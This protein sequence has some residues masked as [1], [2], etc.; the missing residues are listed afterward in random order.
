MRR[1][2]SRRSAERRMVAFC[3]HADGTN[4]STANSGRKVLRLALPIP[5]PSPQA[6][7][8]DAVAS[9]KGNHYRTWSEARVS[10]STSTLSPKCYAHSEKPSCQELPG[11]KRLWDR[12]PE[13]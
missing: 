12:S 10:W 11:G 13:P 6:L 7:Q 3:A 8:K 4:A 1:G 5:P 2:A 9:R